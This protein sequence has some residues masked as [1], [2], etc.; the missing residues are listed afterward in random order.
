ML[1]ADHFGNLITNIPAAWLDPPDGWVF[2]IARRSIVGLN[3]TYGALP[4]GSLVALVGSRETLEIAQREGSAAHA[5][6]ASPGEPVI[7]HRGVP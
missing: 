2:E 5:L 6:S 1:Y 7:A 4:M 3:L